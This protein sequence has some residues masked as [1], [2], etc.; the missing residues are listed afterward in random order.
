MP[1]AIENFDENVVK[2]C[3]DRGMDL[4]MTGFMGHC[5]DMC[6]ENCDDKSM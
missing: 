1:T 6:M 5:D 4:A 3:D 2:H